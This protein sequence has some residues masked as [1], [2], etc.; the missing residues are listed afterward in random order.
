[1]RCA[2]RTYPGHKYPDGVAGDH[3]EFL[4]GAEPPP[5][6]TSAPTDSS[7]ISINKE[8]RK[9]ANNGNRKINGRNDATTCSTTSPPFPLAPDDSNG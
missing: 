6:T 5:V 2:C 3:C 8:N 9:A 4:K 7:N 1:M